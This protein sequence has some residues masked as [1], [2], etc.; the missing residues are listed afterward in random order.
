[1]VVYALQQKVGDQT[2]HRIIDTYLDRYRDGNATSADFIRVATA[3]GGPELGPF[4]HDWLYGSTTPP[5]PG[6]PDWVAKPSTTGDGHSAPALR[7]G[8]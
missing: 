8:N 7:P 5:M 3:V 6:H 4:L 2:F 1:V